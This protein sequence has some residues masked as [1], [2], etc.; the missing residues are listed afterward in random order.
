MRLKVSR[1]GKEIRP[2]NVVSFLSQRRELV[3]EAMRAMSSAFPT[4]A[5]CTLAMYRPKAKRCTSR[6]AVLRPELFQV[7]AEVKAIRSG[8]ANWCTGLTQL[9]EGAIQVFRPL[10][11]GGALLL[12]AIGQLQPGSRGAPARGRVWRGG[13]AD[14]LTPVAAWRA[15]SPPKT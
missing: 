9:G 3:D 4:T 8:T 1:N 5:S 7:P 10:V 11:V 6:T 2:N 14:A 15:G 12:G 13:A